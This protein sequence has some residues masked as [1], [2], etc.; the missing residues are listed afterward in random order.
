MLS[1]KQ[2]GFQQ[3]KS[4]TQLLSKFTDSV[5]NHLNNKKHVLVVFVDYSKAFD[6]LRHDTLLEKLKDNGIRGP[7]LRW[8]QNY[9]TD[10]SYKVKIKETFSD[11]V[12]VT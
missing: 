9:M 6:M 8:C 2:Y 1:D 5:N 12:I 7:L 3:K 10:R 11:E 4:A